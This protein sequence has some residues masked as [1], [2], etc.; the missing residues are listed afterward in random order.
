M[1][2]ESILEYLADT[3]LAR[4]TRISAEGFEGAVYSAY[5]HLYS[6][7]LLS[8]ESKVCVGMRACVRVCLVLVRVLSA[9]QLRVVVVGALGYAAKLLSPQHLDEQLP[10]L[11]PSILQLYRK[12]SEQYI[13]SQV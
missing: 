13:L 11:V 5:E 6:Q 4:R 10:K 1:F 2:C 8:K 7:W 9:L 3:E 12:H